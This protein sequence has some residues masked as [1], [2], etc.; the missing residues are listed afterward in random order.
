[1]ADPVLEESSSP[2][3]LHRAQSA[4]VVSNVLKDTSQDQLVGDDHLL[5]LGL[6]SA[7][8][9][10]LCRVLLRTQIKTYKTTRHII[11]YA[12]EYV[13][14]S[15]RNAG[16]TGRLPNIYCRC[17]R[18][19]CIALLLD[20]VVASYSLGHYKDM[21]KVRVRKQHDPLDHQFQEPCPGNE[22]A[23]EAAF[24]MDIHDLEG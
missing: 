22:K 7:G 9:K 20:W 18:C 4:T 5:L 14:R 1:M 23:Q 24:L 17:M 3:A 16:K 8:H 13:Y 6:R 10:E 12:D 11:C 21:P 19:G 2:G 15:I